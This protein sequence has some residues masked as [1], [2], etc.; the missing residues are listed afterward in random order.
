[1]TKEDV[2]P[3]ETRKV[4]F[5]EL[6]P[7]VFEV[8]LVVKPFEPEVVAFLPKGSAKKPMSS[9]AID[10]AK[11]GDATTPVKLAIVHVEDGS[12]S[13]AMDD[14]RSKEGGVISSRWCV[15]MKPGAGW[16]G[17]TAVKG[18]AYDL[19]VNVYALDDLVN[20]TYEGKLR[21]RLTREGAE[22]AKAEVAVAVK[23]AFER[24]AT[25]GVDLLEMELPDLDKPRA[26]EPPA[27]PVTEPPAVE[28]PVVEPPV[29]EP[30]AGP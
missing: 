23:V 17:K 3:K 30:P 9:L 28:P 20:G 22:V 24:G 4:A 18:E 27:P 11:P 14:L 13:Y 5:A 25:K 21:L 7:R 8:L 2:K 1:V 16:D 26:P 10:V 15:E 12:V 19:A 29:V 6:P